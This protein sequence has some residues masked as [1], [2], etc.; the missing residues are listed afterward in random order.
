[1]TNKTGD[2]TGDAN[3]TGSNG[4]AALNIFTT[5]ANIYADALISNDSNSTGNLT[6]GDTVID[7][8]GDRGHLV[9]TF[10]GLDTNLT[11]NISGG[12]DQD[13]DNFNT[14]WQAGGKTFTTN[15]AGGS[16]YGTISSITTDS[17]TGT[18]DGVI[19]IYVIPEDNTAHAVIAGLTLTAVP[20]PSTCALLAGC[21]ALASVMVRRRRA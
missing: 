8:S 12:Y 17:G 10:T 20:E 2:D 5:E 15:G 16:G 19:T 1:V 3:V 9:L 14:I 13:N 18:S 4:G 7:G 11:Y 6:N 21:L